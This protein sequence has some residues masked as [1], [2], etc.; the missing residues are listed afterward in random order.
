MTDL[1]GTAVAFRVEADMLAPLVQHSERF[2]A[3]S[4]ALFE[5]PCTA[6][7]PDLVLLELND[8]AVAARVGT[9]ALIEPVDVRAMLALQAS[10]ALPLTAGELAMSALVSVEHLRRTVLPRLI[11]GGHVERAGHGW[12]STYAFRSLARNI[13]TVEAKIRNWR[14]GLAQ[15]TRHTTVADQAWLVLDARRSRVAAER[16]DWFA[17]YGV[18]LATLSPAGELTTLLSPSV[19]RS[20]QPHRELLVERAVQLHLDGFVSGP[21]PRVF[22]SVL[23]ASTGDD[24]RLPGASGR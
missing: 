21:V 19:N 23:I 8:D 20:R 12:R 13:V 11:E 6:G 2:L 1:P 7:V 4:Q 3:K 17:T 10:P 22:G 14:G 16:L 18:G 5:V 15:A 9:A 24:P